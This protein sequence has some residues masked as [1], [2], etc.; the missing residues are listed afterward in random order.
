MSVG[1]PYFQ[2]SISAR[3]Q[4]HVQ[5]PGPFRVRDPVHVQIPGH[6]GMAAVEPFGKAQNRAQG[7]HG[8]PKLSRK[9]A[10]FRVRFLRR[11][12]TVIARGQCDDLDLAWFE[13]AQAAVANDVGRVPVVILVTD[14]HA[15][16]MQQG[17][18]LEPFAL[19]IAEPV[20]RA[21]LIEQ[22]ER[23][24]RDLARVILVV[25]A[26]LGELDDVAEAD[27]RDALDLADV[28]AVLLDVVQD[29]PFAQREIAERDRLGAKIVEQ[30][31]DKHHPGHREVGAARIEA[32]QLQ[33]LVERH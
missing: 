6:L 31:V 5:F 11:R 3:G 24:L 22:R 14:V 13:A 19:A 28:R 20:N 12:Q 23:E 8:T 18:E 29:E 21:R 2:L 1:C 33:P 25:V 30:C 32:G 9:G 26:A 27:I 15:D 16:V 4:A 17:A 10:E 7:L